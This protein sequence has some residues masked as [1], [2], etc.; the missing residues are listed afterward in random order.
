MAGV[1]ALRSLGLADFV[2]VVDE[3][4]AGTEQ[5]PRGLRAEPFR[6]AGEDRAGPIRG[7][8]VVAGEVAQPRP[9]RQG[10]IPLPQF[11]R[12]DGVEPG[13]CAQ[14]RKVQRHLKH[15]LVLVAQGRPAGSRD[16]WSSFPPP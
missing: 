4:R 15:R 6:L 10:G 8:V 7:E 12:G 13:E 14:Q 1:A 2:S 9:G 16:R 5:Q 3:G 11:A